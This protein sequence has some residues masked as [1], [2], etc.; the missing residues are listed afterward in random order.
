MKR[1]CHSSRDYLPDLCCSE[2]GLDI[3]ACH[4][5]GFAVYSCEGDHI[6]ML[7]SLCPV[8][9]N[10]AVYNELPPRDRRSLRGRREFDK[11]G[12]HFF[13]EGLRRRRFE[14]HHGYVVCTPIGRQAAE[15]SHFFVWAG[16]KC[17]C[18]SVREIDED[19][20]TLGGR[21][22]QLGGC[23]RC[24]QEASIRRYDVKRALIA[25]A[26]LEILGIGSIQK[27]QSH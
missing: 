3:D 6:R 8:H 5:E 11:T 21:D 9:A 23:D 14:A 13:D 4:V 20:K 26:Q 12:R 24:R 19:L 7:A 25:E 2:V 27:S 22:C 10:S 16:L 18:F 1:M 17:D 15:Y